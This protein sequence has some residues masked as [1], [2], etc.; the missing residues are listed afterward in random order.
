MS[1]AIAVV[2]HGGPATIMD[3]RR[4]RPGPD[5]RPPQRRPRRAR[6]Q[7]PAA[8]HPPHGRARPDPPRRGPR[9]S[10]SPSSTRA[11]ADPD[12][13]GVAGLR[14]RD[15][16]RGGPLQR[17]G[18]RAGHRRTAPPGL[19]VSVRRADADP[20]KVLYIGGFGRCGEHAGGARP[21]PAPRLLLGRRGRLHLAA[22]PHREP[23][24]RLRRALHGLPL[25]AAGG[26]G[27]LRR[28]GQGRPGRDD[29]P[30]PQRR[31]EP[32]HPVH[33]R[34]P[35]CGPAA[36]KALDALRRASCRKL[37]QGI[38]RGLRRPGRHRRLQARL[39]RLPAPPG[40]R[41]LDPRSCTWCATAGAWPTRGPSR[42][43]SPRSPSGDDYMP[44]YRPD[45]SAARWVSYNLMFDVLGA[46]DDTIVLRYESILS[47]PR[48]TLAHPGPRRRARLPRGL[49]LPRRR[50]GRP[51]RR[52][53]R[54]RQPDALPPRAAS[55]SAWTTP[56]A[57]SCPPRTAR[58]S[59][60]SPAPCCSATA[61]ATRRKVQDMSPP[62]SLGQR[63]HRH[64]RPARAA[65]RAGPSTRSWSSATTG[66]IEVRHRLRPV[67]A[68]PDR[69]GRSPR[70]APLPD[71][72]TTPSA[73]PA[74][75]A[76]ATPACSHSTGELIAFCDD[77]DEWLPDQAG[78]PGGR[79]G[80]PSPAPRSPPPASTWSTRTS[81]P[82]ASSRPTA[83]P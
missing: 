36:R 29:R 1:R 69:G 68:A 45:T 63:R 31:P 74:W 7:P 56:G 73:P 28:L 16:R 54:G 9:T 4:L 25:L 57:R 71:A 76:P 19:P 22:G 59:R 78:A 18:R 43:R 70:A 38:A 2:S 80:R 35:R 8:L 55:T 67:R 58:S 11:L 65:A 34:S 30:G 83:S 60:P 50:L 72:S 20:T 6:R 37:Y 27:R 26:Q 33:G 62:P 66:A 47:D 41:R 23:A 48:G 44:V 52:P 10:C 15:R 5:R 39:H 75:P 77:D 32:L 61:T 51:R 49:R 17:D 42:S 46:V 24:V 53:H 21:R 13:F 81:R 82:P 79:P 12:A 40:P 14:R 64:P 3:A